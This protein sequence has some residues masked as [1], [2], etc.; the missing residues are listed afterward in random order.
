M[1]LTLYTSGSTD[2]PKLITHSWD[3]IKRS[4]HRSAT[5]IGLTKDDIVLD[6][7]PANTIAH[8]TI[9]GLPAF[10]SGAQYVC[11]NFNAYTYPK[12][13]KHVKP[14]YISLIPRHLEL[15]NKTKDF[16]D[17][18][19]SCV[20]YMVTGSAKI[21]QEFIDTFKAKGVQTIANWYGMTE[22]PPPVL[23]GYDSVKF[24]MKSVS[25][26]HVMFQSI[27]DPYPFNLAECIIN[28]KSTGDIFDMD[29]QEFSHRRKEAN[30]QT[31]KT[32]V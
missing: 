32:D 18:D 6:V 7:F 10:V 31:W 8:Y 16:K 25:N 11:S 9:T 28:G 4:A 22:V 24:N 26:D 30:G 21:E 5:E 17:L 12:L 15:L 1:S 2:E 27:H 3:F 29:K 19:M 14:T 13:F 20:R 23:I